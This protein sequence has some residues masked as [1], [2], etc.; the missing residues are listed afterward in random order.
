MATILIVED[1]TSLNEAYDIILKKRGHNTISVFNGSEALGAIQNKM[2]DLV[3]LDLRMPRMDGLEFLQELEPAKK[4]PKLRVII[5]SNYDVQ[6]DID[7]AFELGATR[8]M[9]KA[10][11]SP[12]ELVRIVDDTLKNKT[13]KVK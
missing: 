10:W 2:P 7:K 11:A 13:T 6:K 1:E 9:L 4:Y 5:F 8:Y 3:L 12:S